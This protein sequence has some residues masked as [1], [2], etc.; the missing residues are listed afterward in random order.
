[1]FF[2]VHLHG[3][4]NLKIDVN[5]ILQTLSCKLYFAGR[6]FIFT[7]VSD[8]ELLIIRIK[9]KTEPI[10]EEAKEQVFFLQ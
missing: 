3:E 5:F 2:T 9:H 6:N 1:M 7:C 10:K 8:L 4:V